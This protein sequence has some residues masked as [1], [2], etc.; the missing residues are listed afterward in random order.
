MGI[1]VWSVG[2]V[3]TAADVDNWLVPSAVYKTI[4]QTVTSSTALTNDNELLLAVAAPAEYKLEAWI[5]FLANSAVDIKW[6]WAVPAGASMAYSALHNE[7]G[8]TGFGS[9][10]NVY[11]DSDVPMAAGGSPTVTAILMK[12]KLTTTTN[13]GTL[14][15]RWAQNTSNAAATHVRVRSYITLDRIG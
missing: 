1:P 7:G 4:D 11:V 9:S 15:F 5:S 8:G 3:L 6:S 10:A 2:Q 12:G 14:Q 13:S